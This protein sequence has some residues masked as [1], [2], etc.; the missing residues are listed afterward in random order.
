MSATLR[1]LVVRRDNIGDLVCTTPLLTALRKRFPE[2][3]IGALVNSYNAPVLQGN[4]DVSQV[5]SYRKLKHREAGDTLLSTVWTRFRLIAA[6]RRMKPDYVLL[7]GNA[8]RASGLARMLGAKAV[9]GMAGPEDPAEPGQGSHEV[10]ITFSLARK[11]GV[12]GDPPA[13]TVVPDEAVVECLRREIAAR[14]SGAKR[15]VGVHISARKP[16]QRWPIER[17][18]ELIRAIA[19]QPDTGVLLFWSP[20]PESDAR[21]PGDDEK[22]QA[23]AL[24]L[25]ALPLHPVPTP[26]LSVLIAGLSICDRVIC[27]DGGAMHLAAALGRPIVCLFGKSEAARWHPWAVPHVLL[28][29]PSREVRDVGSG[30]V[31]GALE[32]LG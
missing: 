9:I 16:S 25:R 24:D 7:A 23:L 31:L 17:Y 32:R 8:A 20:G 4:P 27:S 3:W 21:H 11:L 26:G 19:R 29:P 15:L 12:T 14:L 30:E 5:F 1:I 28:Q 2:A 6:L 10:E 13:P 22:A 18:A